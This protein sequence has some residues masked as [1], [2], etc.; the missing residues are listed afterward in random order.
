MYAV[1][2]VCAIQCGRV[3]RLDVV[4]AGDGRRKFVGC[5]EITVEKDG[6]RLAWKKSAQARRNNKQVYRNEVT[7]PV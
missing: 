7:C 6:G 4:V 2:I 1:R 5:V 3:I